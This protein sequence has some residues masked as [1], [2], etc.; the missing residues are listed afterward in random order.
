MNKYAV[1]MALLLLFSLTGRAKVKTTVWENP[2]TEYGSHYGNGNFLLDLDVSKVEL[3]TDETMVHIT[4]RLRQAETDYAFQLTGDTYLKVGEKR[5]YRVLIDPKETKE[6][7]LYE[8]AIHFPPLPKGTKAF[9]FFASN[10]QETYQIKGIKPA[11]ERWKQLF[12]SYWS[13]KQG[14]WKIAFLDDCAIY[15]CK[16]WD[17][18]QCSVN[19]KTGEADIVMQNGNDIVKVSIGKNKKG[20]RT[21]QMGN[22]KEELAM[23][24]SRYMPDYP[25]KD[26]RTDFVDTDYKTD[27]VTLIGWIKDMPDFMKPQNTFGI[28]HGNIYTDNEE[29]VNADLDEKGRFMIKIPL[30]NSSELLCD[31]NR[32][33]FYTMLEPGK[34]YFLLYDYKEGRRYFMGDDCRLQNELIKYP[35]CWD[36]NNFYIGLEGAGHASDEELEQYMT[37]VDSLL[38]VQTAQLDAFCEHHPTLSSRYRIFSKGN[39]LTNHAQSF[40]QARF[41]MR[42]F[43]LSDNARRYA[44]DTFWTKFEH[45]Y[46]LHSSL[47]YFMR[48]YLD[49]VLRVHSKPTSLLIA[50]Y[51]ND[52]TSSDEEQALLTRW[53][54]WINEANAKI[55]AAPTNEEKKKLAEKINADNAELIRDINQILNRPKVQK[56]LHSMYTLHK[57]EKESYLLDSMGIDPFIKNVWLTRTVLNT[58]EHDHSSLT[59]TVLDS[60][61][62]IINNPY[63]T[64]LIEEANKHYLAIE[65][66][67][68]DKQ[69]LKSADHLAGITEGEA[70]LKKIL[71]PYKG[72]MVLLDIWGTWCSPCKERL[73][74]SGEEY[75]RLKDHN[76]QYLYLANHSPQ[77]SWENVIKEYQVYGPNVA[78]Y[79]LPDEQQKA[80]ESY[81]NVHTWPT[82]KLFNQNGELLDAD[83]DPIDLDELEQ[84]IYRMR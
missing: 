8:L 26:M 31:W 62:A 22:Q 77:E 28:C 59:P 32:C 24:T 71:E 63:S 46:T 34:T 42:N 82:Y 56:F 37:S 51:I 18:R 64:A 39:M 73:S 75:A 74:H 67:E 83:I 80:I 41:R 36:S 17:Y 43:M 7:G 21:I 29:T 1:I 72:K 16:F 12:P 60:M 47:S 45:P 52:I 9:D 5:F 11:E 54:K 30:L 79:N 69:V 6:K 55:N 40:G 68:F 53:S 3:K 44:H 14:N 61:T 19:Q 66:R 35:P 48:D 84:Q 15:Q 38:K 70:L 23:I 20:I 76:I 78:H 10:N 2:S 81:L 27:T 25:T 58:F 33:N 4:A 49:D 65:N 13:D 57:M 50:D